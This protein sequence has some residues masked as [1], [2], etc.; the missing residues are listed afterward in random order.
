M[1]SRIVESSIPIF[2]LTPVGT[3]ECVM[4]AG[5]LA[6]D[7]VPPRLTASFSATAST[8]PRGSRGSRRPVEFAYQTTR[9]VK[10]AARSIWP[11]MIWVVRSPDDFLTDQFDNPALVEAVKR[12]A[13]DN[14][15]QGTPSWDEYLTALAERHGLSKFVGRLRS[16]NPKD[17]E[18]PAATDGP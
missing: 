8:L 6:S 10:F 4:L 3:P 11:S 2:C 12:E 14:L 7:S 5:K 18:E 9:S 1:E 15:T 16:W 13:A 17:V